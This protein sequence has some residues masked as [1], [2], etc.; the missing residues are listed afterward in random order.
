MTD[1]EI[2]EKYMYHPPSEAGARR[3]QDLSGAFIDLTTM[4]DDVC[5]DGREKSIVSTKLEEAKFWASAAVARN[6]ATR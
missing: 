2:R 4:I 1:E 3:H 5:P 6:P